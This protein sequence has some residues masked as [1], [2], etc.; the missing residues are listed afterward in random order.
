MY[1]VSLTHGLALPIGLGL[2][3]FVEPCSIGS[4]L[5]FVKTLEGRDASRK[6]LEVTVFALTRALLMGALGMLAVIA[7]SGFLGLQNGAWIVLGGLYVLIGALYV[8][9]RIG[10]VM[11]W[12]GPRLSRFAGLRASAGLGLLFGLNVP[13]CAAPLVLALLGEATARGAA[14]EAIGTGFASLA[15]FGL[16]LSL[17]LVAAALFARAREALDWLSALS[18][19][20]PVWAGI[21]LIVLGLWSAGSGVFAWLG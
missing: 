9:G 17:P 13:A 3:G 6:L 1:G 16:A 15:L 21:V 5:L 7:G 18:R 8:T 12:L 2:L 19:R 20:A 4:T 14:G 10:V 11:G